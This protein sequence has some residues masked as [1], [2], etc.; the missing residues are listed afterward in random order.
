M[1]HTLENYKKQLDPAHFENYGID[2]DSI[3][4]LLNRNGNPQIIKEIRIDKVKVK[5]T[6]EIRNALIFELA[7]SK[8]I[9]HYFELA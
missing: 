5:S 3:I 4:I 7:P 9:E 8:A 2:D 6:G 1:L